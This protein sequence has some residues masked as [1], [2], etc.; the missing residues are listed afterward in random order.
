[1]PPLP[2]IREGMTLPLVG[3]APR[4]DFDVVDVGG[5]QEVLG[6]SRRLLGMRWRRFSR[7]MYSGA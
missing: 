5:N 7:P 2:R 6:I 4:D 3:I 1:M